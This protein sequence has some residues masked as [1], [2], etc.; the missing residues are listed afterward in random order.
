MTPETR[1]VI[2]IPARYSSTRFPGKPLARIAGKPM[3][4]F[5]CERCAAAAADA[6][7]VATDDERIAAVVRDF[8]VE[9]LM[10]PAGFESGTERVAWAAGQIAADIIVN[11]QG[12]EPLIA[13]ATIDAVTGILLRAADADIATAVAQSDDRASFA[14]PNVVKAAITADGRALYFSRAPIPHRRDGA[15]AFS[16]H[17]HIG[18]YAF[19]RESLARFASLPQSHLE[20]TERLEQLRALEAGMVIKAATVSEISISVDR[21]SD[22]A[23]V[24]AALERHA[25]SAG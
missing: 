14:D 7:L 19:R 22:I 25:R 2:I 20:Q 5:V 1:T 3:I 11:V 13:P 17:R 8:G 16:F 4:K 9:A 10:T 18:I 15:G 21:P 12:D 24:E 6:V 23:L